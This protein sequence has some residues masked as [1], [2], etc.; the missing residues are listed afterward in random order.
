MSEPDRGGPGDVDDQ[1]STLSSLLRRSVESHGDRPALITEETRHTYRELAELVERYQRALVSCGVGKGSHVGLLMENDP[2]WV[3]FA[4]AAT[5]L[6]ALLVP[7]S[8]FVRR[9]DLAYQLTHADVE[10]LFMTSRFLDNDYLGML[11]GILPA[12]EEAESGGLYLPEVPSLRHVVVRGAEDPPS[13]CRSWDDFLARA[14]EV[15]A[16]VVAGLES[17]VDPE[18]AC[19]LLTTSGTTARPKG[20]LLSHR[21]VAGNG[22]RIGDYQGLGTDDVVWFYFPLFF[23][24]GCVNVMLGALS[25]G[26]A[27]IIQPNLDPA[28]TLELIEREEA[29]T[30][31]LWPHQLQQLLD[32]PD[33][34]TRDHSGLHKGTAPYDVLC[35]TPPADGLGGVNMYGMTETATAFSCTRADESLDIRMSTQGHLLPGN[36]IK[37]VDPE[38]GERLP[39]GQQGELCVRGPSVMSR[40]YKV[41]PA[42][43]FDSEGFFPT[44]DAGFVDGDGR[45]HFVQRLK[46]VIK[47]GGINVSPADIEGSLARIPGVRAAHVFALPGDD[48]GELVGVA[49]VPDVGATIDEVGVSEFCR[50][51]LPGYKR[52]RGVLV[53]G[54][55]DVPMTGT[56]KVQKHVLRDR[57]RAAI[58]QGLGPFV[59]WEVVE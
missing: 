25:H 12:L 7:I 40:Y 26:A 32:H 47:T 19:Y 44:G 51:E 4:F 36:E 9:D 11:T 20:V 24:A 55:D 8:T 23:S 37:V 58:D 54:A 14:D 5:G 10:Y 6:G 17:A 50:S 22:G 49:L 16:A 34:S 48:K 31:H 59:E 39:D 15:P 33:W 2:H 41:D 46:D 1:P 42:T 27:L 43:T 3:A 21:A 13:G 38:T 28:V 29:T 57:L 52:P 56:G 18:D 45:V 30:W 35:E 53:L